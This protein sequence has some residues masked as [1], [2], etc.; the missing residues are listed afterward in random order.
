MWLDP[1]FLGPSIDP[2]VVIGNQLPTMRCTFLSQPKAIW[3]WNESY[4]DPPEVL[5]RL[6]E[7]WNRKKPTQQETAKL[8]MGLQFT[9]IGGK[10]EI[11]WAIKYQNIA[12]LETQPCHHLECWNP[13]QSSRSMPARIQ[14]HWDL[15][16]SW[17]VRHPAQALMPGAVIQW[18]V[19]GQLGPGAMKMRKL[20][21]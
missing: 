1:N 17:K 16:R 9:V 10:H 15:S 6:V 12:Q 19:G 2:S 18:A 13:W 14:P 5:V 20:Y 3:V 4:W 21:W 7:V 11:G 8:W